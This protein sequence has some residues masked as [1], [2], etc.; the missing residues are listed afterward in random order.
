[1]FA[2]PEAAFGGVDVLVINAGVLKLATIAETAPETQDRL[3]DVER[4]LYASPETHRSVDR[5]ALDDRP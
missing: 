5:K 2:A 1:M 3:V 4:H